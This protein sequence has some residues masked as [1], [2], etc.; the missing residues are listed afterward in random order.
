LG[1]PTINVNFK[2]L[3]ATAVAR[4]ERGVLAFVIK[5]TTDTSF[6]YR[7]YGSLAEVDD[8][9]YT[10]A[11]YAGIASAFL[12]G[13]YKVIVVRVGSSD[14]ITAVTPILDILNF[15]WVCSNVS[16]FHAG[17]VTYVGTVNTAGRARKIKALVAGQSSA[18]DIH[19]VNVANTT[20]TLAGASTTTAIDAYLPRLAGILAACPITQSVTSW[21]LTDLDACSAVSTIDTVIDAGNLCLYRDDNVIRIARGVNTLK[22]LGT[23]YTAEM[24]KIAVVE[25]MDLLQQDIIRVFKDNY[26]GKVRNSADNQ[27][28]LCAA[29]LGYMRDLTAMGVLDAA[30]ENAVAV[31]ADAIRAAW[32]AAGKDVSD[33]TDA[34]AKATPYGSYVYLTATCRIIDAMEDLVMNIY[35]G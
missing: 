2:K 25:V 35:M 11:N 33:W 6:S 32:A 12:A 9:D 5:D 26:L 21:A 22:T 1:L 18:D 17:L 7:E 3:A 34:Q 28:N 4:S 31:D 20:V 23:T 19:V 24:K 16:T 30:G 27:G 13:P 10:A 15:D 29:I 14:T 8:S